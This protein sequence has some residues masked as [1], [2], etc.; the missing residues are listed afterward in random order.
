VKVVP[1]HR[2]LRSI[3]LD[4]QNP[5]DPADPG[6]ED[7]VLPD[8]SPVTRLAGPAFALFS[9]ALVPWIAYLAITLPS[10]QISPH[11]DVAWAGFDALECIAL[12][13][14]AYFAARRS[15]YLSTAATATAALLI[16]DAWFDCMTA[17]PSQV[18]G[19]ILSC[20][21]VE[22]PLAAVCLWLSHHTIAIAE[23]QIVLLRWRSGR[24][25]RRAALARRAAS[26][27]RRSN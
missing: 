9:V 25:L 21:L 16:V 7:V 19:S 27:R 24:L 8:R 10:R 5:P 13:A 17:P 14:T 6:G 11:Y 4:Q 18:L 20:I 26:F 3:V 15:L 22:L 12:A 2:D 1:A 23:R